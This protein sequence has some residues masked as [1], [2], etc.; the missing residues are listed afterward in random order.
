MNEEL[1]KKLHIDNLNFTYFKYISGKN[2]VLISKGSLYFFYLIIFILGLAKFDSLTLNAK[3]GSFE[4]LLIRSEAIPIFNNLYMKDY[5][6]YEQNLDGSYAT[7][8]KVNFRICIEGEI[9]LAII[10]A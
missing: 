2:K 8:I 7:L 3:P 4:Y 1:G 6:A 10:N 9:F 5:L